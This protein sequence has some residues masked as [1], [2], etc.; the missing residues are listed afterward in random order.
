MVKV[1][2]LKKKLS[3]A[4]FG[5]FTAVIIYAISQTM[6]YR[7]FLDV[8]NNIDD[9]HTVVRQNQVS[10]SDNIVIIDID[11]Y[12]LKLLGNFKLWPRRYFAQVISQVKNGGAKFVFLDVILMHGGKISDNQA[13][14]DSVASAG[15]VIS[16]YY[17]NLDNQSKR[18]RPLDTVYNDDFTDNWFNSSNYKNIEFIQAENITLPFRELVTSSKGL[19]FTNYLPD[20]DGIVRHIPLYITYN[21]RLLPSAALQMW[22]RV[23]GLD[24]KRVT[25]STK[26][27][28]FGDTFVP[29]DKHCFMR[30]NYALTGRTYR[31]ISLASVMKSQY[32]PDIF[33]DKVVMIGSS[34]SKLGDLKKVPGHSAL[35]GVQI[36]AAA[37]STL[38]EEKFITVVPGNI[39]FIFTILAGVLA[40]LIFSFLSPL[41]IGIPVVFGFPVILYCFSLYLFAAH[42]K[43]INITIPSIVILLL[44][45]VITIHRIVE[46]Y[47]QKYPG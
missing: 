9:R 17:V 39:I 36:H 10:R 41:K 16:G 38:L 3:T 40:A 43:L 26:G 20:P 34:S 47:E 15:N 37:L 27:S 21:H 18:K 19:G 44:Y 2:Q 33:R 11:D 25:I 45:I 4:L 35:P 5:A 6:G 23:K 8:Q 14:V 32:P 22:L 24:H 31:S 12:S 7:F 13:L 30:L 46:H 29:T 28:R 1:N 42:M